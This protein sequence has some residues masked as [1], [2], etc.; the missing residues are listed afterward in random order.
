MNPNPY[1]R[2][3]YSAAIIGA[4]I[5][6]LTAGRH[7]SSSNFRVRIFEKARGPGGRMSTRREGTYQFDHGAQFLTARDDRFRRV[8]KQWRNRGIIDEW[9]APIVILKNEDI[10]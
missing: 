7:L 6:G 10:S 5:S 2:P 1:P 3:L 8:L 4:G 9:D